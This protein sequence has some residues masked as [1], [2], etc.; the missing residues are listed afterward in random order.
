MGKLNENSG[1]E[2]N[3]SSGGDGLN[4]EEVKFEEDR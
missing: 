1:N 3:T 2:E 4:A